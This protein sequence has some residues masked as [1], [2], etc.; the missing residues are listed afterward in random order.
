MT[1]KSG[2]IIKGVGGF[3]TVREQSGQLYTCKACGRFRKDGE[4]PLPG[5]K[6][7]FSLGEDK[8]GY[9]ESIEPRRN[10]LRRPKVANVDTVAI[11]V[12]AQ[13][14]KVDCLLCDKL[15]VE[16]QMAGITPLLVIN[17][18]DV[19]DRSVLD[20]LKNEYAK[21]CDMM[22]VSAITGEGL[23][24][25]KQ[26]LKKQCTC[27]AGQSAVGKTSLINALFA[28]L[29]LEV[30]GLAKKTD[31]GKHTTRHAE[32]LVQDECFVV[33]TPGF[34][35]LQSA[36][37]QP[38]QLWR[39]YKDMKPYAQCRFTSCLHMDEPDCG[40]KE[41]VAD[42]SINENRYERYTTIL[43]ELKQRRENKYD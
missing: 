7:H 24:E 39:E 18:C 26:C 35:L 12:S 14:P 20:K 4:V 27:L 34:S 10:E 42:G 1:N 5:D 3:Y 13:K 17:K 43:K 11:V 22:C 33:D 37:I 2:T 32:L 29:N 19:A 15:I 30:G 25:L 40:V 16:A 31:R 38:E 8:A 6:V 21:V 36:A 28:D 9:I 41:A 23:G